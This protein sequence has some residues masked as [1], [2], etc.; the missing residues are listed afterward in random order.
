LQQRLPALAVTAAVEAYV[1]IA[2]DFAGLD[3]GREKDC[4]P[5]LA[6]IDGGSAK[7][8]EFRKPSPTIE[9]I[10]VVGFQWRVGRK[11]QSVGRGNAG[12]RTGLLVSRQRHI[13][14]S[15]IAG[16]S[17]NAAFLVVVT[18]QD[19][20]TIGPFV[21]NHVMDVTDCAPRKSIGDVPGGATVCGSVD[22]YFVALGI[23]EVFAPED[24]IL[25]SNR[26]VQGASAPQ[27]SV[28]YLKFCLSRS[29]RDNRS[30]NGSYE[31]TR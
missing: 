8:P 26:D 17:K 16:G 21:V 6:S 3:H 27:Q 7:V 29:Q 19:P 10:D 11:V 15:E 4:L 28:R 12:Y 31:M 30:R 2:I 9:V 23:I 20:E 1:V 14:I 25:W 22:V 18:G 5:N 13:D 24:V